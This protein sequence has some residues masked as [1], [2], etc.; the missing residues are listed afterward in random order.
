LGLNTLGVVFVFWFS[1]ECEF[2]GIDF[3]IDGY[4]RENL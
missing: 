4:F 3:M 2:Y 1:I